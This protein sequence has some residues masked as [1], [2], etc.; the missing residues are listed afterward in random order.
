MTHKHSRT[1]TLEGRA[2]LAAM[3][4]NLVM[5]VLGVAAAILSN[6]SAVLLDGLFSLI[7]FA[8]A[9]LARRIIRRVDAGPDRIRPY[10]YAADEAIFSTFRALSLLGLIL[11]AAVSAGL[12]IVDFALGKPVPTVDFGPVLVYFVVISLICF[13]LWLVHWLTYRATGRT[14]Q[15]L[16]LEARAALSD[17]ILTIAAGIGMAAVYFLRDGV[18][19]PIAAIGDSLVVLVLCLVIVGQY[20]RD[21]FA[22]VGELAG[23]TA[24]PAIVAKVRRSLR[25]AVREDGGRIIDMSVMKIGRDHFVTVYYDP[26]RP[27]AAETVDSLNLRMIR[28][29]SAELAHA[30]V[31]V[32]V[33]RYPRRWP[34]HINPHGA[35]A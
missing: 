2:L 14:S 29:V 10:G 11:F 19:A 23:V 31:L 18:L 6:S 32:C 30:E 12:R 16:R 15:I 5:G 35:N 13:S 21:L 28:D 25:G 20:G 24:R 9:L 17:G 4:G 7:G 8:S 22:S 1:K 34:E 3:W 33:S 26:L 27:I